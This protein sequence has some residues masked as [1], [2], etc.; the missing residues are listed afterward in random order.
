MLRKATFNPKRNF[1]QIRAYHD[2]S[3]MFP[4]QNIYDTAIFIAQNIIN[5]DAT[6]KQGKAIKQTANK[7]ILV[8]FLLSNLTVYS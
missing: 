6:T 5:I 7:N 2:R 3:L 4:I 1:S 8:I